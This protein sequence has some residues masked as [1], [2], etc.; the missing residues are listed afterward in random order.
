MKKIFIYVLLLGFSFSNEV[1]KQIRID[2]ISE[3]DI[4]LFQYSGIDIDHADY[5]RNKY[6]EFAISSKDLSTLDSLG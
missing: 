1:Y 5:Q 3:D 2:N 4:S 6:I